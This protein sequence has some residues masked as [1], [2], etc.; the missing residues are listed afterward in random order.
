MLWWLPLP[1]RRI[2]STD[3]CIA[4]MYEAARTSTFCKWLYS[5]G[6]SLAIPLRKIYQVHM[7]NMK[8]RVC[9]SVCVCVCTTYSIFIF[10]HLS[11]LFHSI[12]VLLPRSPS[13]LFSFHLNDY[14]CVLVLSFSFFFLLFSIVAVGVLCG[15]SPNLL[16]A[17][18]CDY[19]Y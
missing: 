17:L 8:I 9:M 11:T 13:V 16:S 3:I 4:Y 6:R 10:T 15:G 18:N 2:T 19:Y 14:N 12:F 1:S 7:Y 5:N